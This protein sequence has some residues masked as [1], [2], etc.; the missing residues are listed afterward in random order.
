MDINCTAT[1][2]FC[3]RGKVVIEERA[4]IIE[5]GSKL[6]TMFTREP[7]HKGDALVENEKRMYSL[8]PSLLDVLAVYLYDYIHCMSHVSR[9]SRGVFLVSGWQLQRLL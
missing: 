9:Q 5:T 6:E 3:W 4:K 2:A 1:K 8:Y 7:R